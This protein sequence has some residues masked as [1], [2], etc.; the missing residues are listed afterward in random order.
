MPR[1]A[2]ARDRDLWAPCWSCDLLQVALVQV[3]GHGEGSSGRAP[4]LSGVEPH[5]VCVLRVLPL[6]LRHRV[7]KYRS[8][9]DDLDDAGV[10][11]KVAWEPCVAR[12][13][14]V[15]GAD[16]IADGEGGRGVDG[17]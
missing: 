8:G 6:E 7:G 4:Q 13:R 12:R 10:P 15:L 3:A 16:P 2:A 1:L 9:L 11:A 17:A 14:D 5:R